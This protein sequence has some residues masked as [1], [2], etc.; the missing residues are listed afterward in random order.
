MKLSNIKKNFLWNI[1]GNATYAA[2]Q[3][4]MLIVLAKLGSPAAVGL[5]ALASAIISPIIMV[6]NMQL[7]GVIITDVKREHPFVDYI[8]VRL[9]SS[10]VALLVISLILCIGRFQPVIIFTTFMLLLAKV[11]ESFSDVFYGLFQQHEKMELMAKSMIIKGILSVSVLG[12]GFYLTSSLILALAGL[13]LAWTI[14]FIFYDV[15]MGKS[16]LGISGEEKLP[17][18]ILPAVSLLM[19]QKRNLLN[20][21]KISFPLGIVMSILSL[22]TN[23]P[24]YAIEKFLGTHDLG[25]FAALAYTTI[26]INMFVHS[27]GQTMVPRLA[28]FFINNDIVSFKKLFEK[29]ILINLSI[30]IFGLLVAIFVGKTL[31]S[32]V[33]T[34]EY[35]LYSNLFIILMVSTIFSGI[36]SSFGF[37]ITAARQFRPQVPLFI[38][39][40]LS[41]FLFSFLAIPRFKLIG[42][43]SALIISALIQILGCWIILIRALKNKRMIHR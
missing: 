15:P 27:L 7:C 20:I 37:T 34:P 36:A 21:I 12:I 5:F 4:G 25:I 9:F 30:G 3:W 24:R 26:V 28:S 16:L 35:S 13:F 1:T 17:L 18:L 22:N 11:I 29:M 43:A 38:I 2:C 10:A 31:L 19:N 41:T 23:I 14:V 33:Y 42:A 40:L 6:T 8:S 39:V 32:L